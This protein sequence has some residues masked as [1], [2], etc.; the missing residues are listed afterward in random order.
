MSLTLALVMLLSIS[1]SPVAYAADVGNDNVQMTELT[2]A[3]APAS[4]NEHQSYFVYE[5]RSSGHFMGKFP[6]ASQS[7]SSNVVQTAVYKNLP[8][9][10][11][12]KIAYSI[13]GGGN[14]VIRFY[15]QRSKE[16]TTMPSGGFDSSGTLRANSTGTTSVWLSNTTATYYTAVIYC[17][18]ASLSTETIY[19]F[20]LYTE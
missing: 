3:V 18:S 11:Q 19:A 12:I 17:S 13:N 14:C 1:A 16:I 15:P 20:N 4:T 5:G 9:D 7:T 8:T 2:N 10:K 6:N